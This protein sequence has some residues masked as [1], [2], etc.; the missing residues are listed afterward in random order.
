MLHPGLPLR[1]GIALQAVKRRQARG[2]MVKA[3]TGAGAWLRCPASANGPWDSDVSAVFALLPHAIAGTPPLRCRAASGERLI[4][5]NYQHSARHLGTLLERQWASSWFLGRS[6]HGAGCARQS[7]WDSRSL[8]T[9]KGREGQDETQGPLWAFS[10][11]RAPQ[12][13]L[14]LP[15]THAYAYPDNGESSPS[16]N[17]AEQGSNSQK[18][19]Q[20]KVTVSTATSTQTIWVAE[21]FSS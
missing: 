18:V 15:W 10:S 21:A 7:P 19:G 2:H 1:T 13:Y 5:E 8:R 17:P 3:L 14:P 11:G 9:W 20:F 12:F 16:S 4:N 6:V